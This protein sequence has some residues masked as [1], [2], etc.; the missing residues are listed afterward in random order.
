[1]FG[2]GRALFNW[3]ADMGE[4]ENSPFDRVKVARLVG[5]RE[6]RERHLSNVEI[7]VFW[8]QCDQIGYPFGAAFKLLLL[9]GC[10]RN[11][12]LRAK[13]SEIDGAVLTIPKSRYKSK[14]SASCAAEFAVADNPREPAAL[15]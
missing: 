2:T 1:M 9:T 4:I 12:I 11:E 15:R 10:R 6:P 5:S 8:Q 14:T 13:W 3:L 7:K